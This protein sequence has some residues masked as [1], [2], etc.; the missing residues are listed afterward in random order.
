MRSWEHSWEI[1]VLCLISTRLS[2]A[3]QFCNRIASDLCIPWQIVRSQDRLHIARLVTGDGVNL[4]LVA[5]GPRQCHHGSAAQIVE[6][7]TLNSCPHHRLAPC[8]LEATLAPWLATT[9]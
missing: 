1:F 5:T 6:G 3:I 7:Q 2:V 9:V 4:N 8:A